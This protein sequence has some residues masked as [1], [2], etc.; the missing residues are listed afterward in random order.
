MLIE[1]QEVN[2]IKYDLI[3]K[4]R[5]DL[6]CEENLNLDFDKHL[7]LPKTLFMSTDFYFGGCAEVMKKVCDFYI[8]SLTNYYN[9]NN[10]YQPLNFE[11]IKNYDF[12]AA[13]FEY[14]KYKKK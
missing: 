12:A 11:L 6:S 5:T 10:T 14:L 2:G 3:Y 7:H 1:Y 9:C 4:I 8:F 13:K